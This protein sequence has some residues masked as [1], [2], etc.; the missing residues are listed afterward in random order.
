MAR[1]HRRWRS[2]RLAR[3]PRRR[4]I[5]ALAA[6]ASGR[7]G[8]RAHPPAPRRRSTASTAAAAFAE[9]RRQVEL[10]PRPAGS[11]ASRRLAA[12]LRRALPRGRFEAVPGGLRN[13]VGAAAGAQAGDRGRRALRHEGDPRLRRRQRRRG[14][15]RGGA[16][17]RARAAP[18]QAPRRRARRAALR[19]LRRRG[20][21]ATTATSF[22][23]CAGPGSRSRAA[24]ELRALVPA[25]LRRPTGRP[26]HRATRARTDALW[27]RAPRRRAGRRRVFP[28]RAV[29]DHRRPHPVPARRRP[30]DRPDRLRLPV[31]AQDAATT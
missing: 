3:R 17:A 10:G 15:D 29:D 1:R 11:A 27:A 25:R 31:L 26:A 30:G 12:R 7:R 21:P 5:V 16:R 22:S 9:L 4:L 18:R 6:G 2:P 23:G 20:G 19:P 24:G 8:A 28:G 14:R 13:V